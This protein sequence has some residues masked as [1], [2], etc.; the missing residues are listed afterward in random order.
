MDKYFIGLLYI[1]LH[2]NSGYLGTQKY[3]YFQCYLLPLIYN[4]HSLLVK[5]RV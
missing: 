2:F 1:R 5:K 3:P 4:T